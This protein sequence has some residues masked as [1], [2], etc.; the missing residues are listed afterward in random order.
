[1][2][3]R[4]HH[5]S[6]VLQFFAL[7]AALGGLM[8]VPAPAQ[9]QEYKSYSD[10]MRAAAPLLRD[11]QFAAAQAPLEAAL[12]LASDDQDRLRTYQAL[13][14]AYRL[15][16]QPDKM[17]EAHEFVIRHTDRR[18][19]R[20]L[21][22]RDLAS[23]LHQRGLTDAAIT[24]YQAVLKQDPDD[25]AAVTVLA[26]IYSQS[27]RDMAK[28]AEFA[29]RQNALDK[30]LASEHAE[31]LESD[32]ESAPRTAA[33]IYKDAAAAWIEAGDKA[34]AVA[35]VKKSLASAPEA[36]NDQLVYFWRRGLG[37]TLM[38]AGEPAEAIPQFEAAL[39]VVAIEGYRKDT[40]QQ[41]AEARAAVKNK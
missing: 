10:A 19:G 28:A 37:D 14:P 32:A 22:A 41:L 5:L 12:A 1:M 27:R 20:S 29:E 18:T 16:P 33:S 3:G 6:T 24:R 9:A 13:V 23:F 8:T 35:A 17:Y 31:R 11:R 38:A 30:R 36:R 15:L 39:K 7:F 2:L 26:A 21:P 4:S 25:I 34:R 40:E